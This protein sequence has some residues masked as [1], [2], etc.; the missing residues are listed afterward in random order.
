MKIIPTLL[1]VSALMIASNSTWAIGT[2]ADTTINNTATITYSV[3]AATQA[4]I[5]SS[6]TGNSAPNTVGTPTAF[7]VD[8]KIDVNVTGGGDFSVPTNA[9]GQL[10][11]FTVTNEGNSSETFDLTTAQVATSSPADVF[12]TSACTIQDSANPGTD[13]TS[14]VISPDAPA[15]VK[16]INVKC[17]TPVNDG[18]TV[19]DGAKSEIALSPSSM[20]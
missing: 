19:V 3:G 5:A 20:V 17:T 8:K 6:P 15:N 7:K 4:P 10:S 16:T 14:I 9:T 11:T 1:S 18:T 13:I 12:D 2:A